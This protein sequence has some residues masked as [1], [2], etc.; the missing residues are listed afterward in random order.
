MSKATT[1]PL[2]VPQTPGL[3]NQRIAW[4]QQAVAQALVTINSGGYGS[5]LKA[6]TTVMMAC[7]L[8][9]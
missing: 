9:P 5:R 7:D 4:L 1:H 2:V 6:G 3:H 8:L